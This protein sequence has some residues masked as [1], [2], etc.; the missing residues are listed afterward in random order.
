[1]RWMAQHVVNLECHG[2]FLG[3][4]LVE[5]AMDISELVTKLLYS[6]NFEGVSR[7]ISRLA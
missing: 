2:S 3:L 7:N 1:M 6:Q 4:Q 5:M